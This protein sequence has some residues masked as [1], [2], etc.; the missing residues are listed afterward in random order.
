VRL[1]SHGRWETF[2]EQAGTM[3]TRFLVAVTAALVS[4]ASAAHAQTG[5]VDW[6]HT[7]F[8]TV[9]GGFQGG[10]RDLTDARAFTIYDEVGTIATSQRFGGGGLIWLGGGYKVWQSF[11]VGAA[12]SRTADTYNTTIAASVPHPLFFNQPR[13]TGTE[14]GGLKHGE[15][16]FHLQ[17]IWMVP[18]ADRLDL[19]VSIGPS[20]V[21]VTHTFVTDVGVEEVGFPFS[22]ANIG[23]VTTAEI[24]DTA[25]GVNVG[26]DIT[27]AWTRQLGV[28]GALRYVRANARMGVAGENIDVDAGGFQI[29]IGARFVF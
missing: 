12:I 2:K 22:Q 14:A 17:A 7:G 10:A 15:T 26:A 19:G 20:F 11:L 21:N 1:D 4:L 5:M 28:T 29:A 25:I 23:R 9:L 24:S 13:A 18:V 8:V 27:Y 6:E 16:G 3:H